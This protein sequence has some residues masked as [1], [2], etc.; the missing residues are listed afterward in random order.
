LTLVTRKQLQNL[1]TPKI[2]QQTT[3]SY[4]NFIK[5][6]GKQTMTDFA[7]NNF[8][9]PDAKPSFFFQT[10]GDRMTPEQY[11]Q[12]NKLEVGEKSYWERKENDI[13]EY[14][15]KLKD[16]DELYTNLSPFRNIIVRMFHVEAEKTESGLIL[17]PSIPMKEMTQNGI[18]IRKTMNTPWPYQRRGVVVAVPEYEA[19]LKPGD[20]V[21]V[22]KHCIVAV[23]PSVDH[24]PV[25]EFGFTESSWL[26]QEPPTDLTNRH[27]GYLLIGHNLILAKIKTQ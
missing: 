13:K 21:E 27:F 25:L 23:K 18:G 5:S 14:N 22:D 9:D 26:S 10:E 12:M 3:I 20:V 6:G 15:A 4:M 24:E 17:E 7:Q 19:W 2:H 1:K 16:L 11:N 8:P